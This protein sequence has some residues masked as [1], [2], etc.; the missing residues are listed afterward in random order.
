MTEREKA[1][2]YILNVMHIDEYSYV[3]D[4][5][6]YPLYACPDCED[7]AFVYGEENDI[8]KCFS[9]EAEYNCADVQFCNEC[10]KPYIPDEEDLGICN[11]CIDYNFSKD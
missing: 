3:K 2:D 4:G 5:A 9:C 6:Q 11:D 1:K 10:G 8:A 7:E